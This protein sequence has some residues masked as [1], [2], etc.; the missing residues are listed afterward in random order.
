M[1]LLLREPVRVTIYAILVPIIGV[2]VG[3]GVVNGNEAAYALAAVAAVL[4]VPAT[5]LARGAVSPVAVGTAVADIAGIL[6]PP[7]P[8]PVVAAPVD[9]AAPVVMSSVPVVP[10]A[11]VPVATVPVPPAVAPAPA[12]AVVTTA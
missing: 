7:A 10:A 9:V 12:A 8:A 6:D 1:G 5:E 4:G 3:Y 2:L 11:E